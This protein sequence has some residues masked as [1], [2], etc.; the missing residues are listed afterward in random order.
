ML[1]T[2]IL[3]LAGGYALGFIAVLINA[4]RNRSDDAFRVLRCYLA[5]G[6]LLVVLV[7]AANFFPT[8][9]PVLELYVQGFHVPVAAIPD[10][11]REDRWYV[12]EQTGPI[13]IV[14]HGQIEPEPFLDLTGQVGLGDLTNGLLGLVFHPDFERNGFVY[15]FYND[16]ANDTVLARYTI[17]AD[18]PDRLDPQSA[19]TLLH[20]DQPGD[21]GHNG[22]QMV[23]GPDGFLYVGLGDG[24]NRQSGP[25]QDL[26]NLMGK[27]IRIDVSDSEVGPPYYTIPPDNPFTGLRDARPEIW[28]YGLR[29]PWRFTF[30][31]ATGDLYVADVGQ[32]AYEEIN[33]IAFED[34]TGANF[35]W[36]WYEAS[37]P[38][39]EPPPDAQTDNL[40]FPVAE[41]ARSDGCAIIGGYVYRGSDVSALRGKY[42]FADFCSG[43]LQTLSLDRTGQWIVKDLIK[44]DGLVTSFAEG[45]DG[46]IYALSMA[47]PALN[48]PGAMYRLTSRWVFAGLRPF[49]KDAR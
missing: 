3:F 18:S 47:I 36:D 8:R 22:G 40:V 1:N 44:G 30:H 15:L 13:L 33:V 24:T 31:P 16:P 23:F 37:A 11:L 46:E 10:P 7:L 43:K 27:I 45:P 42:L 12:V 38:Y 14:E 28:V 25:S 6:G 29:N 20:M 48:Q 39:G 26:S 17:A 21:G 41:Y 49:L 2:I 9:Q 34:A 32:L 4:A 19:V 5:G 35:G